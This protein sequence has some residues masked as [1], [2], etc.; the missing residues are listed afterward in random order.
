[1]A[2]I[3]WGIVG[4]GDVAEVK[5]GPG[6]QKAEGSRLVAVMRRDGGKAAD[7]ARRHGVPR[8][9][10]DAA[11]LIDDPEVDA[12]YVATPPGSH[13]EL[14]LQVLR[15]GKPCYVEKPM[16]RNAAE[17]RRMIDAFA[18]AGVPLFVAYYRR[19]LPRFLAAR[20]ALPRLGTIERVTYRF[21]GPSPQA[22]PAPWRLDAEQA[23]GGLFLDLG[24]HALDLLDFL[25]GPLE[26]VRG[27]ARNL[28]GRHAVED[29]VE[30]RWRGG[31]ASWSFTSEARED[32]VVI[33]GEAGELAF[34]V[35][36]NE[37][38]ELR[39][40]GEVI[41]FDRPNPRHI[42]Q[43]LIQT[44]VDELRGQ[45]RCPSTGESASRTQAV[46]D[47]VLAGYYGTRA[48]GFWRDPPSWPGRRA[49]ER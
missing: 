38:I 22:D 37:P 21:A 33:R 2:S 34:S 46:M 6:F 47:R 13:E 28:S 7:F 20:D 45:G 32:R 11:R 35:F 44:I 41:T 15:A 16:A 4:C 29:T 9:T 42:Q 19:A 31:E 10:D 3:R 40:G 26:D 27:E 14:A 8:W 49:A 39:V 36:G 12:V 18:A 17:C 25:L 5:S 1:V 23:G 30:L 24:C 48:D 43:P